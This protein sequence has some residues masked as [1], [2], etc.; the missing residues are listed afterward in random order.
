M[1][2]ACRRGEMPSILTEPKGSS[3]NQGRETRLA[4]IG[5]LRLERLRQASIAQ[6]L[7]GRD[8]RVNVHGDGEG[9]R[10]VRT[11][12][13]VVIAATVAQEPA[14]GVTEPLPYGPTVTPHAMATSRERAT[15][16]ATSSIGTSKSPSAPPEASMRSMT[17]N[18][19]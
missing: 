7:V 16:C 9:V 6:D 8:L 2:I 12:P 15:E 14:T 11:S 13:N 4:E 5:Y 10:R 1:S 3:R 19:I 17:A 18:L